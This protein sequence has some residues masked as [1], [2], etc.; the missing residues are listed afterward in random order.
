MKS[1]DLTG[2]PTPILT[3]SELNQQA[4]DCLENNFARIEV[5]GEISDL[6]QH[7]SGHWYF[8]L[9]DK[10]SQLRCAMF[11]FQNKTVRFQPEDGQ[12]VQ[13]KGKLS[14]YAPRGNYQFIVERM[15]PAGSGQLQQAFDALKI[16]LAQQGWFDT[17]N[18]QALPTLAKQVVIITSPQGAAIRD[19]QT[20]FARRF[21]GIR[22]VVI[23]VPVQGDGAA[24]AISEAIAKANQ[25]AK[26]SDQSK[27]LLSVGQKKEV[28]AP[29][30]IIIGRGGGSLEDLWAFNELV[31][32]QAIHESALP[33]VSAVG[34]ETDT[35]IAD[36]VADVRAATPTAAAELLSPD[37]AALQQQFASFS[38][39]LKRQLNYRLNDAQSLLKGLAR[40]VKHPSHQLNQQVQRVDQLDNQLFR[41]VNQT[42]SKKRQLLEQL[43][44]R[45]MV[46]SPAETIQHQQ[47]DTQNLY[48]RLSL[49]INH[50]LHRRQLEWQRLVETLNVVSP[51]A[52]LNRGYSIVTATSGDILRS[53]TSVI[54]GDE[55][56]AKLADGDL[57]CVVVSSTEQKQK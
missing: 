24:E 43:Q 21:A 35:T 38:D 20:T 22:L 11:K 52:T 48:Q 57:Q 54:K 49:A 41:S 23:P 2:N 56:N 18:K 53:H 1:F 40:R 7:R 33:I 9:K 32:A 28:L 47:V 30:A 45:L 12:Q 5:E 19:M 29:E 39:Q 55:I 36:L 46:S 42:L 16:R 14:L 27:P 4:R 37:K 13:L 26:T 50:S 34:H 15:Q 6:L 8:T 3:V 10:Q 31:V 44:Q 25:W 17:D 51:L